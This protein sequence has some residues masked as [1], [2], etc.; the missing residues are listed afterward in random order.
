MR[1]TNSKP[2]GVPLWRWSGYSH[3]LSHS[4]RTCKSIPSLTLT[5]VAHVFKQDTSQPVGMLNYFLN[6]DIKT[7]MHNK[8]R[9][10]VLIIYIPNERERS[11]KVCEIKQSDMLDLD[12]ETS[13][14]HIFPREHIMHP[15]YVEF[16][17]PSLMAVTKTSEIPSLKVWDLRNYTCMMNLSMEESQSVFEVRFGK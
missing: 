10:S 9:N 14:T 5:R 12:K 6:W 15:G 3:S 1:S 13:F 4:T 11:I 17:E 7:L 2:R 8:A 16:D